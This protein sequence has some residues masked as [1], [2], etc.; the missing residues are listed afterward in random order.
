MILNISKTIGKNFE[1]I[2][3][4]QVGIFKPQNS[5]LNALNCLE[6]PQSQFEQ[7]RRHF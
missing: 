4:G 6:G 3:N 7:D 1:I 5:N 2:Q